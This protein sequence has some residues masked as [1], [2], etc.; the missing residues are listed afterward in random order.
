MSKQYEVTVWE[1]VFHT[2]YVYADNETE[3]ENLGVYK[4]KNGLDGDYSTDSAGIY[5]AEVEEVNV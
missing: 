3:A 4:V 2:V 5:N 1:K